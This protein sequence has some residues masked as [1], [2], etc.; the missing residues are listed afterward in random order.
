MYNIYTV[1][2]GVTTFKAIYNLYIGTFKNNLHIMFC[3]LFIKY[4]EDCL[5]KCSC[6]IQTLRSR[7]SI[8]TADTLFLDFYCVFNT[9][10]FLFTYI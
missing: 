2:F 8:K 1:W 3:L 9:F 5:N 7:T 6:K 10:A 4:N